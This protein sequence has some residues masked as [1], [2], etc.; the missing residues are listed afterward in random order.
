MCD[1]GACAAGIY[2]LGASIM[3]IYNTD[4]YMYAAKRVGTCFD[5]EAISLTFEYGICIINGSIHALVQ[6]TIKSLN[7]YFKQLFS[8]SIF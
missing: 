3:Y 5:L 7:H 1:T 6:I 2:I 8:R 4:M